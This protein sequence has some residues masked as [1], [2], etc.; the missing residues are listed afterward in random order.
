MTT[1]NL[2]A[3]LTPISDGRPCGEDLSFSAAFDQIAQARRED[4]PSLDQGEWVTTLKQADWPRV[5]DLTTG[6]LAKET[7][8]IRLA[9]WV[10]EALCKLQGLAGLA[11]GFDLLEQLCGRYW[12]ELHP[13]P[14]GG[15]HEQ[16]GGNF[17]WLVQRVGVL[18]K[19]LPV[20]GGS[21]PYSYNDSQSA[22]SLQLAMDRDPDHAA[23]LS[24]NKVTVALFQLAVNE[25]RRSFYESLLGDLQA[26]RIAFAAFGARIDSLLGADAPSYRATQLALDDV[27]AL[28]ERCARQLG[29]GGAPIPVAAPASRPATAATESSAGPIASR[30]QAMQQL[31]LVAEYFRRTEPHSPVA[32]LADKA[33][34]WG[35]MPLHAWLKTVIKDG[36]TLSQLEEMLGVESSRGSGE[37]DE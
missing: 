27:G 26:A 35:D 30:A 16:R 24:E 14:E 11:Q 37:A 28:I 34:N 29:V 4:D 32:Y 9:V 18:L 33:A 22:Q 3:L 8:D 15:D 36:G 17:A 10:T 12:E 21:R 20:T 1:L 7:K 5:L 23:T 6:L 31:R 25:S 2:E 13:L 19:Q